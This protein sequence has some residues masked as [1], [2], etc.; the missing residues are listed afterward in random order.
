M[1]FAMRKTMPACLAGRLPDMPRICG[2]VC[3]FCAEPL[4]ALIREGGMRKPE[5]VHDFMITD[6]Y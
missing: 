3:R 4:A 1:I 5:P 6:E 2:F